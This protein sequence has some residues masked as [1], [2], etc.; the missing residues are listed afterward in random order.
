MKSLLL[1]VFSII[2]LNGCAAT[3]AKMENM[4]PSKVT[5]IEHHPYG[6]I[7]KITGGQKTTLMSQ[8]KISNEQFQKAL[9]EAIKNNNVF[10]RVTTINGADYLLEVDISDLWQPKAGFNMSVTLTA[11]WKITN[12]DSSQEI[13]EDT[14]VSEYTATMRDALEGGKRLRLATEG[15]ARRNIKKGI[16]KISTLNLGK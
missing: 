7:T 4:L 12:L 9:V 2:L 16:E 13:W 11:Y 14:I 6:V 3:P 1:I 10:S 5:I 8:S 15:A